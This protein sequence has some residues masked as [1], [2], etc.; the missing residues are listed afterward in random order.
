[1][2]LIRTMAK[3]VKRKGTA[4]LRTGNKRVAVKSRKPSRKSKTGD[5]TSATPKGAS[6]QGLSD[7]SLLESSALAA[8]SDVLDRLWTIIDSRKGADPVASHSARLLAR[9]TPQVVQKL[10]EEL[11]ECL[12]EAMAGNH[13]GLVAESADVLYHLLITWV[14]AGIH[15][16]EVWAELTRRE[17]VSHL[18][19]GSAVP[20]KRLLG[21]VQAGT[22]KIP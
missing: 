3:A 4:P 8:S 11:V 18:T 6:D 14:N 2:G 17:Q 5:V 7:V 1:M 9:G 20:L 21:G 12:I 22:T 15:P 19:E 13:A 16:E 10:G